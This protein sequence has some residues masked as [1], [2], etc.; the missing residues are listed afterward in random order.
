[1]AKRVFLSYAAADELLLAELEKH[2]TPLRR[3]GAVVVWSDRQVLAG[4]DALQS[5]E[6]QIDA[7]DVILLLVTPDFVASDQLQEV[8][9]QRALIRSE[10]A[11][12]RIVPVL[13]RDC[14]WEVGP[15]A[16]FQP[17]PKNRKSVTS[18]SNSDKAWK[19]VVEGVLALLVENSASSTLLPAGG[20]RST[21]V[22]VGREA[23][24]ATLRSSLL[25]DR[26]PPRPVAV[27]ALHGMAGVGKSYLADKFAT[28]HAD[29]FPGGVVRVVL[30]PGE[31]EEIPSDELLVSEIARQLDLRGPIELNSV[32]DRLRSPRTL[33]H[34]ENADSFAAAGAAARLGMA[35]PRCAVIVTGRYRDLGRSVGFVQIDVPVLAEAQSLELL[36]REVSCHIGHAER[37]AHRRL[38]AALGHLPLALSL[39][40]GYLREGYSPDAFLDLLRIEGL[41]LAPLDPAHPALVAGR[42][43]AIVRHTFELSLI[44]LRGAIGNNAEQLVAGFFALGHAPAAGFGLSYGAASSGLTEGD[45]LRLASLA[46]RHSLLDRV[47]GERARWSM[48]PLI[49]EMGR[50]RSDEGAVS[51]RM[52]EWFLSRLP[53]SSKSDPRPQGERWAELHAETVSL[54]EW[55]RR[56]APDAMVEVQQAGS[57]YATSSGP[58]FAWAAFCERVLVAHDDW[59]V[60]AHVLGTLGSLARNAGDLD[61]ALEVARQQGQLYADAGYKRGVA[62]AAGLRADIFEVR[63]HL[64]EALRIRHDE[65]LPIYEKTGERC[66]HAVTLCRISD[67]LQIRGQLD[68]ALRIVKD[69]ALPVYEEEGNTRLL[70]FA[71][72]RI[73]DILQSRGQ[74][75]ETLRIRRE[76]QLPLF[77]KLGEIHSCAMTKG[78]IAYVLTI[79]GQLDEALRILREE[80]FPV[81][82]KLGDVSRRA[83]AI[84]LVANIL[85][86]RSQFDEALQVLRTE[87]LPIHR[88]LGEFRSYAVTMGRIA[89]ILQDRGELDEAFR[90]RCEEEL[91]VFEKLGD[92]RSRA[93]TMGKVADIL[94]VRGQSDE[95]LRIVREVTLPIF[96]KLGDVRQI[97]RSSGRIADIFQ[98]VGQLDDAICIRRNEELPVFERVGDQISL[99][100]AR[101][102]LALTILK[103]ADNDDRD[104]AE[105]LLRLA[106]AAAAEMVLPD[107]ERIRGILSRSGLNA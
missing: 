104:E 31:Q 86:L 103:R 91:P 35:L 80:V 20:L 1:M 2:L 87:A 29:L 15:L 100:R 85:H 55:L 13:V 77:E 49:A 6:A 34:L 106:L 12:A 101:V 40:A 58:F 99:M 72:D 78:K 95:A 92:I 44:L 16:T 19:E 97:A 32:A 39:A 48:H 62:L 8:Q 51:A 96:S 38:A 69:E 33:L 23:E 81:F 76:E 52:T 71:H 30:R 26:G 3:A 10:S 28:D 59:V 102:R 54:M 37:A 68:E 17:L 70:A 5:I 60:H 9:V 25:P 75:D 74:L 36:E 93:I 45:F 82:E 14:L 89:D 11:G 4:T 57:W 47:E 46:S 98:S 79:R 7:A 27:C 105:R 50:G 56:V 66:S 41:E 84:V 94:R 24:L 63:G 21:G 18:W 53:Q 61:R 64:D 42:A 88:K 65:M 90:I 22:F 73:A 67:I 83:G 107:M 43:R